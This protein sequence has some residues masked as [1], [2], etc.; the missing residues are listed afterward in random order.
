VRSNLSKVETTHHRATPYTDAAAHCRRSYSALILRT[1]AGSCNDQHHYRSA[2]HIRDVGS[3]QVDNDLTPHRTNYPRYQLPAYL[4]VKVHWE[5]KLNSRRGRHRRG[6]RCFRT[7]QKPSL[8]GQRERQ[9]P[10][11]RGLANG[12]LTDVQQARRWQRRRKGDHKL[13]TQRW[14]SRLHVRLSVLLFAGFVCSDL[15]G[16]LMS[17]VA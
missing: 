4:R 10:P 16:T 7:G 5:V 15:S 9:L 12:L 13:R 2:S 3:L 8:L 6:L 17:R 11:W 1:V 14:R